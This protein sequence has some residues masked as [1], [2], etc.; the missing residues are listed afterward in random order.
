M[1]KN[2]PLKDGDGSAKKKK[3]SSKLP[4]PDKKRKRG[5]SSELEIY[6][7]VVDPGVD[8]SFLDRVNMGLGNYADGEYWQQV[9]SFADFLYAESAF[10]DLLIERAIDETKTELALEKWRELD[11][12]GELPDLGADHEYRSRQA[13]IE[14]KKAE[15]WESLEDEERLDE[16]KEIAGIS[17]TWTPPHGRMLM[18]RHET[19]RSREA[20]LLDN[21]FGRKTEKEIKDTTDPETRKRLKKIRGSRTNG[22]HKH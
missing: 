2:K 10:K 6:D 16:L 20:R 5:P 7:T 11:E 4:I 14:A 12:A 9:E 18:M 19:S 3:G 17:R 8:D 21:F 15:I 1:S 13:W 22:Q